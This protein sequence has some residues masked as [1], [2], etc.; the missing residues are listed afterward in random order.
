MEPKKCSV[1]LHQRHKSPRESYGTKGRNILL[2]TFQGFAPDEEKKHS[3]KQKIAIA[4][5]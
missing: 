4:I 1:D 5:L 3:T 2:Q